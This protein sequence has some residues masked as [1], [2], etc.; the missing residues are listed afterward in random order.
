MAMPE[1][2]ISIG[3]PVRNSAPHLFEQA[4]SSL[5]QQDFGDFEII[6]SDNASNP[7]IA[8]VYRAA[9]ERDRRIRYFRQPEATSP[10][11]NFLFTLR[12]AVG[13]FFCWAADDDIRG[14]SFLRKT[15]ELLR[16]NPAA[17]LASSEVVY[18]DEHGQ[19]IGTN[20]FDPDGASPSVLRRILSIREPGYYMDIYGLY[21]RALLLEVEKHLQRDAW[22]GD[23]VL[24]FEMLLR[25]PI[26][27]APDEEFFYRLRKD[28]KS[29]SLA[30]FLLATAATPH[31]PRENWE[32][33]RAM[34]ILGAVRESSLSGW[35][36][37]VALALTFLVLQRPPFTDE[38][39]RLTKHRYSQAMARGAYWEAL[40]AAA[41]YLRLSPLAP[42]RR[43]AWTRVLAPSPEPLPRRGPP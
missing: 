12:K 36:K 14:P 20:V 18:I 4:L 35:E 8:A 13:E 34:H 16:Q 17:S 7:D 37:Q 24:V 1:P 31:D 41:N 9:A 43:T 39:L 5:L 42:F 32:L 27:R 33:N 22:G 23:T 6:L 11:P 2:T 26:V 3:M 15:L 25:G 38:R 21:R 29:A 40:R 10:G 19:R 30:S 28:Y